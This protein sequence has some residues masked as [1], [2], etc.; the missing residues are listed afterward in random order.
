MSSFGDVILKFLLDQWPAL[1]VLLYA[2]MNSRTIRAQ[3][4]VKHQELQMKINEAHAKIDAKY[5][6][7]SSVDVIKSVLG[8]SGKGGVPNSPKGG[9]GLVAGDKG[10]GADAASSGAGGSGDGV[11]P[12]KPQRT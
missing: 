5:A 11:G 10:A 1:L 6:G 2:W 4:E 12:S 7:M 3:Q 9:S 8:D